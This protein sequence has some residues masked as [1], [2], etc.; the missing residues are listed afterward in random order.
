MRI[1]EL[2]FPLFISDAHITKY[3]TQYINSTDNLA[4]YIMLKIVSILKTT[5]FKGRMT[6]KGRERKRGE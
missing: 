5:M 2:Y 1:N 3:V 4:Y 6:K